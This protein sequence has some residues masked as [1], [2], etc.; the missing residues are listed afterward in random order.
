MCKAFWLIT[1][2]GGAGSPQTAEDAV[3]KE[4]RN[5]YPFSLSAQKSNINVI[6]L[7]HNGDENSQASII[8]LSYFL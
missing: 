1:V 2:A 4:I 7:K 5:H 8:N 6:K 3:H